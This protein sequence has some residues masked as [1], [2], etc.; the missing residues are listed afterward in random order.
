[1]LARPAVGARHRASDLVDLL[2][3]TLNRSVTSLLLLLFRPPSDHVDCAVIRVKRS[4]ERLSSGE[5]VP[6]HGTR[7]ETPSW[8]G[9]W[10]KLD[11]GA[12]GAGKQTGRILTFR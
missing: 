4:M 6:G 3:M 5:H 7:A 12:V 8:G 1:M 11:L 2:G 10:K 9:L